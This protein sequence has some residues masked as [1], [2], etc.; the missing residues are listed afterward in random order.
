MSQTVWIARHGNRLD[1]VNPE[2]FNTAVR[3]YDP[4]LSEDGLVQAVELGQRLQSENIS[5]ILASP[6]LRT[7]Q[8]A[9]EVAKVLNLPIKLEAGLSEWH[10]PDWMSESPEIHPQDFLAVEYPLIDWN[11]K[12]CIFP[13]Y[14]E[15]KAEVY[16]R[17]AAT[18]E[19]LV[20]QFSSDILIVGHGASV[21]GAI[22]SFIP[23]TSDFKVSLCSLT[24]VVRDQEHHW[25]LE[26]CVDTSH[27]TQTESQI[28]LN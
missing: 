18:V 9:N 19:Q 21:F 3:R 23:N 27:L 12:S 1:F 4:P 17:T 20:A 6:F 11:Y 25:D 24:K 10:N 28:R 13:Q 2:W 16:R 15:S 7:I 22:K 8:T 14:P 5:H 26:L